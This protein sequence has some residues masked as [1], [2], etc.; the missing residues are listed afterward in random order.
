MRLLQV[1]IPTG[2]REGVLDALDDED[3]DYVVADETSGREYEAVVHVPLP[4]AAVEPVLERLRTAGIDDRAYT[5]VLEANTVISRRFED[6]EDRYAEDTDE[7]RIAR[8]ELT[9]AARDLVPSRSTFAI[10]SLI[11]AIIAT[12]GLLLDSPAVIVGSMV[13]APLIGPAMAASVGTVVDDQELFERGVV[14]QI[15]GVG[16]SIVSAAVFAWLIKVTGVVPAGTDVT[17]IPA[18]QER[19][20]PGVLSLIVAVGAGVAGVI[21]LAAGVS[22]AI[23]GVMIAVALIPPAATV[24]I[25]LAWGDPTAALAAGVLTLVNLLS[26]NLAALVVLRYLGYRPQRWF[27]LEEARVATLKRIV[28]L[29]AAIGVLSVVLVGVTYTAQHQ[30]S[31]DAD[32]RAIT[33]DTVDRYPDVAIESVDIERADGILDRPPR[34]IVVDVTIPWEQS[35]PPLADAIAAEL[36]PSLSDVEV[37]V[38][39]RYQRSVRNR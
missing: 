26:I 34:A 1:S 16:L 2:K 10:M 14:Y 8:E 32:L 11:S 5:V 39:Y 15:G 3:L 35:P 4:T 25:A 12:A 37:T 13:I 27:R 28:A 33:T 23:V 22:T 19:L 7:D 9:S 29:A 24:G 6:L 17:A 18:V 30:A 21:S 31:Q 38:R 20:A 36:P